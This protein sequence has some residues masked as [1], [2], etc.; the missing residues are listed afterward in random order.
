M[1]SDGHRQRLRSRFLS[2]GIDSLQEYELIEL[3]LTYAIPRRDVKPLAKTLV[4]RFG[5]APGVVGASASELLTVPGLG[6]GAATFL[7]FIRALL[8][9]CLERK[10][11]EQKEINSSSEVGD[12]LRMKIGI[13]QK[14]SLMVLYLYSRRRLIDYELYRGTVDRAAIYSREV[15]ESA[16]LRHACGVILAHNHPSGTCEP[17]EE[18]ISLSRDLKATLARLGIELVDHV[19]VSPTECRSFSH[20]L[21]DVPVVRKVRAVGDGRRRKKRP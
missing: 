11:R 8:T 7:V 1:D 19:I 20:L 6:P 15:V 12:F 18:D 4:E 14:E 16:L 13:G 3:L 9:R 5:D 10:L 2:R 21:G 17:S